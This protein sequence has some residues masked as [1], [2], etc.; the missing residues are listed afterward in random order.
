MYESQD[1]SPGEKETG[2]CCWNHKNTRISSA[3]VIVVNNLL[4]VDGYNGPPSELGFYVADGLPGHL[5]VLPWEHN[6]ALS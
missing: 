2:V 3:Y 6:V 5:L 4:V 1:V